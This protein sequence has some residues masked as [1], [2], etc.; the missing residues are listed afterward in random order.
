MNRKIYVLYDIETGTEY[1]GTCKALAEIAGVKE[2]SIYSA[3]C[4][5]TLLIGRYSVSASGQVCCNW[6]DQEIAEWNEYYQMFRR[7]RWMPTIGPGVKILKIK[8]ERC[9]EIS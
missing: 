9:D 4:T 5:K 6:T 3:K 1:T 8:K 2:S 7:V